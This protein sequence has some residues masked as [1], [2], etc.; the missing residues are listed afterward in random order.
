ML[1]IVRPYHTKLGLFANEFNAALQ[2]GHVTNGGKWVLE[3]EESLTHILGVP[4][5]AFSSGMAGLIAMLRASDVEGMEVICPSFTFVATAHAI[6][7]AGAKPVFADIDQET[8]CLNWADAERRITS[9]TAAVMPVDPYGLVCDVPV[10]WRSG[11]YDVLIDAAPSFGS[12]VDDKYPVRRGRAQVYSFHAT[13]P[14][15][16]M[17][18]GALCSEDTEFLTKAASIRNFGQDASGDCKE[19]GFNGKMAEVNALVGL[20]NLETWNYRATARVESGIRMRKALDTILGIKVIHAPLGQSPI[21]TYQPIRVLPN[22]GRSRDEVASLLV[23]KGI[24]VRKYYTPCHQLSYYRTDFTRRLP[25]TEMVGSQ[26]LSLP[27][28]DEMND[29]E[30]DQI[31]QALR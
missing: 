12:L 5:L 31:V 2:S 7:M 11:E 24:G 28:Y 13:K 1:P 30:I 8:L 22:F 19:I 29:A 25:V 9:R 4:T 23:E 26:A 14:F 18:G 3:F 20:R 6:V 21:W 15:S 10:P 27:L 17:E 16:T